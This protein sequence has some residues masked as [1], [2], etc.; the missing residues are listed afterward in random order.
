MAEK[1]RD[2]L[3]PVD[4]VAKRLAKALV[5]SA[6]YA[7]LATLDP[8]DGS[9]SVSRVSVATAMDGSPIFLM[10]RLSSHCTNLM[11]DARCSLLVG[12]PGKGDPLAHPRMTLIGRAAQMPSAPE[13]TYARN[14]YLRRHPKAA[15]YA[16]FPDFS[17]WRFATARASLN[18]GFGKAYAMTT[19]D[20][21]PPLQA[22]NALSE[23]EESAI[24]HMNTD[25]VSA[26]ERYAVR[27]GEEPIGWSISTLD[28]EGCPHNRPDG[29][30]QR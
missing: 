8:R 18:G 2:V 17:F 19:D 15:L 9:P 30:R 12:E 23:L 22:I 10:S 28:P 26:I 6:R 3:Q 25:H 5:R 21:V 27:A 29:R 14:R 4:D 20:I 1:K 24:V 16:D 13:R 11:A 7:A